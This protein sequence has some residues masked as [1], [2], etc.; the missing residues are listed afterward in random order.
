MDPQF[1][2]LAREISEVVTERVTKAVSG[3][4]SKQFEGVERRLTAVVEARLAVNEQPVAVIDIGAS[5]RV[6]VQ[7]ALNEVAARTGFRA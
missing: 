1:Q 6:S 2:E 4:L 3:E 7:E 5:E